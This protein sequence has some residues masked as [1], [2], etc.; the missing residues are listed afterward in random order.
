MA[1]KKGASGRRKT[2]ARIIKEAYDLI[3]NN[4]PTLFQKLYEL[5]LRGDKDALIYL[6]DRRLGKP[7]SEAK[8][9]L[10]GGAELGEGMVAKLFQL[11]TTE[12]KA[13]EEQKQ[14]EEQKLLEEGKDV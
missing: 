7:S 4:M 1:G 2:P 8:L 6:I 3:D 12:R 14:L 13:F 9:R 10:E 5:A 11:L